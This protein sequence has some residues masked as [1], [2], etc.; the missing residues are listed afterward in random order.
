ML[1]F[2]RFAANVANFAETKTWYGAGLAFAGKRI[3]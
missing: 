3:R 2:A 1:V